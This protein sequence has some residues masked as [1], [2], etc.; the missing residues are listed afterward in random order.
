MC[1]FQES[2]LSTISPRNLVHELLEI[3][4]LSTHI[5]IKGLA[6]LCLKVYIVG[7]LNV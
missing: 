4:L 5:Y 1:D 3:L 2:V 6:V 7:F